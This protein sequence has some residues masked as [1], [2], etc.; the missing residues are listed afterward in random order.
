MNEFLVKNEEDTRA[1]GITLAESLKASDVIGLIGDLGTGKTT[2]TKYIAE[3]LGIDETITSPTFTV[4]KEYNSGR[5]PLY[6]FDVYRLTSGNDL[7]EIGADDYLYGKGV[8]I[9]EWADLVK[10]GLPENTKFIYLEYGKGE[11]ERIYKWDF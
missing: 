8:S 1:F 9:V 4:V 5:L 3:G 2:L 7:W 11:N 10:D 6:H